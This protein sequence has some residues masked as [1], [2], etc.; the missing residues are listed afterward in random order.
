MAWIAIVPPSTR[1]PHERYQV[2]YQD[3]RR[4]RSA[5]IFPTLGVLK[6]SSGRSSAPAA[7]SSGLRTMNTYLS[8][9][10]TILNADR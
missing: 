2:R 3:G 6:P 7:S 5:G 8:L 10:G 4:Q 1:H 9:L